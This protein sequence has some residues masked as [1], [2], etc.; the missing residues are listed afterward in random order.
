MRSHPGSRA[1][2]SPATLRWCVP[3]VCNNAHVLGGNIYIII[4]YY[5]PSHTSLPSNFNL[6]PT[7]P[8]PHTTPCY[9]LVLHLRHFKS[10]F[11]PSHLI[12]I[13]I[14]FSSPFM[15]L[16]LWSPTLFFFH[17][18]KCFWWCVLHVFLLRFLSIIISCEKIHQKKQQAKRRKSEEQ[19]KKVPLYY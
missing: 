10:Y 6:V 11:P 2:I 13:M 1:P 12:I 5:L 7:L 9:Y 16:S 19:P 3:C 4:P 8:G 17:L 15:L 14:F 18:Y